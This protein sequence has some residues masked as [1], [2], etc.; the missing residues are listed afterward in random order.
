MS[1]LFTGTAVVGALAASLMVPGSSDPSSENFETAYRNS[2]QLYTNVLEIFDKDHLKG[3]AAT[4]H[5][6]MAEGAFQNMVR[7]IYD[8]KFYDSK[9]GKPDES[10]VTFT[11]SSKKE[12]GSLTI[13]GQSVTYKPAP[14]T[15]Q[16]YQDECGYLKASVKTLSEETDVPVQRLFEYAL[17]G[18]IHTSRDPHSDYHWAEQAQQVA[19]DT[20]GEFGGI[21][22]KVQ[23]RDGA[24]EIVSPISDTPGQKAG[25][26]SGDK[27]VS[28]D[29]ASIRGKTLNQAVDI[30]RGK[31]GTAVTLTIERGDESPFDVTVTRGLIK[32][33]VAEGK[34]VG[35]D[36]DIA[37][38][39]LTEFSARA[40]TDMVAAINK[41]KAQAAKNGHPLKEIILDLRNNPG[42]LLYQAL[43]VADTFLSA[44]SPFDYTPIVATG[45]TNQDHLYYIDDYIAG[46]DDITGVKITVLQNKGSASASEI[47]AGAL[48]DDLGAEIIGSRS[49]G[50]GSVQTLEHYG[51]SLLRITTALFFPGKTGLSNQGSGIIP[52]MQVH[53][54]DARDKI[55]ADQKGELANKNVLVPPSKTR[56][57]NH[58]DY[59]CTLKAEFSGALQPATIKTLPAELVGDYRLK[60]QTTG[61]LET[62]KMVDADL[63]CALH[64]PQVDIKSYKPKP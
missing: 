38:V 32:M 52:T 6:A 56:A 45:R 60:N 10:A 61:K 53:Y 5:A 27:I 29:G 18:A 1:N 44:S 59:T 7:T 3:P 63:A 50:K 37:H 43:D 36:K 64:S 21:G 24:V 22:I 8:T 15:L 47:V 17:K 41:L 25:L 14:D 34:L 49:Y 4:S 57:G 39:K 42:G 46:S 40:R 35:P 48:K 55:V 58:P 11:D 62:V 23:M 33:I 51:N 28:V 9:T 31:I 12:I 30:M 26:Q 13:N 20:K 19:I 54:N 16:S 2:C